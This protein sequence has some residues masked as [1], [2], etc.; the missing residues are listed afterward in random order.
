MRVLFKIEQQNR[1]LRKPVIIWRPTVSRVEAA[2]QVT[3]EARLLS[4][5]EGGGPV[6]LS[7]AWNAEDPN[8]VSVSPQPGPD[9]TVLITV[10]RA[11]QSRLQ[12]SS[13]GISIELTVNAEYGDKGMRVDI[14]QKEGI[15]TA[16]PSQLATH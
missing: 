11:G 5:S 4:V 15:M 7:P 9:N 13:L 16:V 14:S 10:L 1:R 6:D 12:V 8:M 2:N 3:V